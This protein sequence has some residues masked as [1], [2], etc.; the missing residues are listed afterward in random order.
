MVSFQPCAIA[1]TLAAALLPYLNTL[2]SDFAF[3]DNFAVVSPP[4][5]MDAWRT[6]LQIMRSEPSLQIYNG[7]VTNDGNSLRG[8]LVHDFWCVS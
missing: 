5:S 2:P 8:L 6:H 1:L 3:D 4:Q 7:D